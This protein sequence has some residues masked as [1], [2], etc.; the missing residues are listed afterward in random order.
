MQL[1]ASAEPGD[2]V[3]IIDAPRGG[4]RPVERSDSGHRGRLRARALE[5]S[6]AT[7][8]SAARSS[9]PRRSHS[10]SPATATRR[11][12]SP[13]GR[14]ARPFHPHR[15][16]RSASASPGCSRSPRRSGSAPVGW[17]C[18]CLGFPGRLRARHLAC[19]YHNLVTSGRIAQARVALDDAQGYGRRLRRRPGLV[20]AAPRRERVGIR[21]RP[22]RGGDRPRHGRRPRRDRRRR[23]PASP[24]GSHVAR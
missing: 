17:R 2:E 21:R 1:A 14:C 19:L 8:H 20:H 16:P 15:R 7:I 23:R 3:G 6:P 11:S 24:A 13:I 4:E 18:R 22:V 9:A 12:R 5:I 10:T